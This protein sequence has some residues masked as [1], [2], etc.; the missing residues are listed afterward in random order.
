MSKQNMLEIE[1]KQNLKNFIP[2]IISRF[3]YLLLCYLVV[4]YKEDLASNNYIIA[5]LFVLFN[6]ALFLL[7]LYFTSRRKIT[8]VNYILMRIKTHPKYSMSRV[9]ISSNSMN[10][11]FYIYVIISA[12]LFASSIFVIFYLFLKMS[13]PQNGWLYVIIALVTPAFYA[14]TINYFKLNF[15]SNKISSISF[16]GNKLSTNEVKEFIHFM[17]KQNKDN[18]VYYL[19]DSIIYELEEK[20][21]VFKLRV[22]TL[23][24]ESVFIGALTFGT[25]V[26]LTS[27]ESI[28][29]FEQIDSHSK[30]TESKDHVFI[31]NKL[32]RYKLLLYIRIFPQDS[33]LNNENKLFRDSIL[34][35]NQ[36][37]N[38]INKIQK[39]FHL[40][41]Q[42]IVNEN[43]LG[44]FKTW[45]LERQYCILSPI[46]KKIKKNTTID[47]ITKSKYILENKES[48]LKS[49]STKINQSKY[50]AIE[51]K[52]T[53]DSISTFRIHLKSRL[54]IIDSISFKHEKE[55]D[56]IILISD[57]ILLDSF[58]DKHSSLYDST[59]MDKNEI[60]QILHFHDIKK[61]REFKNITKKKWD[62]QEY[63]FLIAIGSIICSV[64]YITVLISR[65]AIIIKIE[66]LYAE[67][68]KATMWN[69]REEDNLANQVKAEIELN[70]PVIA[71][72]F[73]ERRHFYTDKLQIQLAHCDYIANKIETNIE[74]IT[75]IRSVGLWLFWAVLLIS[76]MMI[77]P[78]FTFILSFILLYA[79]AGSFFLQE[80]SI[81]RKLW[82]GLTESS[83]NHD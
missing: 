71:E 32:D 24:I 73:E 34:N 10:S 53:L 50:R 80:G 38:T 72:K 14:L 8:I 31:K 33:I 77:D 54:N 16:E 63:L 40:N 26:Q 4:N 42:N 57:Q 18:E 61:F 74:V 59:G 12:I 56:S 46:Y 69:S 21:N 68:K 1:F 60:L 25:F 43:N 66:K 47:L 79:I 48:I 28:S 52:N 62:E 6:I 30:D 11:P 78:R 22:E 39:R 3:F 17:Y 45:T 76:T 83:K 67:I 55:I 36:F 23:L 20:A 51:L 65:F 9:K 29:S 82:I 70:N 49:N 81:L 15:I 41:N 37:E 75:F 19:N 58:K 27:P 2:E 7:T 5:G 13:G 35:S 44:F 64:L